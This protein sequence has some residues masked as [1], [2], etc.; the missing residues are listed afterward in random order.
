[1]IKSNQNDWLKPYIVMNTELR[2]KAKNN[3]EKDFFKLM[4]NSVF[5]KTIENVKKYRD[6]KLIA[7]E[8][9]RSLL[10]LQPNYHRTKFFTE[11]KLAIEMK[12]TQ[13]LMNKPVYLVLSIFDLNKTE[14]YE[15]WHDYVKPN[16]VKMQNIVFWI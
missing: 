7:I 4:N 2:Q 5:R 3:F 15:F 9:R 12:K 16:T 11:N 14:M 8:R 10:V 13:V 6:I 1:M